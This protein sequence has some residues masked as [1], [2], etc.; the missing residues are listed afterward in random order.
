MVTTR[1][2]FFYNIMSCVVLNIPSQQRG[3]RLDHFK[4]QRT[5]STNFEK[6]FFLASLC[7][8]LLCLDFLYSM[9][10]PRGFLSF[11]DLPSVTWLGN[12]PSVAYAWIPCYLPSNHLSIRVSF[13]HLIFTVSESK[14][15]L[16][17]VVQILR[18]ATEA[19]CGTFCVDTCFHLDKLLLVAL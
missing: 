8:M 12:T 9:R 16:S 5:W 6:G 15:A 14:F 11:R 10:R 17:A 18:I 1:K 7:P 4:E 13:R 2:V 19:V 3:Q